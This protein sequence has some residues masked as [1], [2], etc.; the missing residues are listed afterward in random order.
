MPVSTAAAGWIPASLQAGSFHEHPVRPTTLSR[1]FEP[2]HRGA[3]HL[4]VLHVWREG[5]HWRPNASAALLAGDQGAVAVLSCQRI[6]LLRLC[7]D[8]CLRSLR[9]LRISGQTMV[10]AMRQVG[11]HTIHLLSQLCLQSRRKVQV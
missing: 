11:V 10:C 8:C 5:V 9:H 6:A 1:S 2:L 7:H 4:L 3:A